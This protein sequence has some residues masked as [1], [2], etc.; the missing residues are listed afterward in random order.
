MNLFKH[1]DAWLITYVYE[2]FAWRVEYRFPRLNCLWLA[3]ISV[4]FCSLMYTIG[5]S[6]EIGI[7]MMLFASAFA[8]LSFGMI[9]RE[10]ARTVL[11]ERDEVNYWKRKW[12]LR[13]SI[14]GIAIFTGIT[15]SAAESLSVEGIIARLLLVSTFYFMSC[16]PLPRALQK[17]RGPQLVLPRMKP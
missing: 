6:S 2:P 14:I 17:R 10:H 11:R 15:Q 8:S 9:I 7:L 3:E 13:L 4:A 1:F 12:Y 16:N 5:E